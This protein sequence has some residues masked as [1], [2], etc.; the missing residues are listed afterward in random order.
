MNTTYKSVPSR[1]PQVGDWVRFYQCDRMVI[2]VVG[3]TGEAKYYP[4]SIE[5]YTDIGKVNISDVLEV[6]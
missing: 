2:G 6:K 1:N 3:Y 4:W 5:L